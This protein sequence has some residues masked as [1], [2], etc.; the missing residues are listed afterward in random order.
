MCVSVCVWC[1]TEKFVEPIQ[2]RNK[3]VYYHHQ[4]RRVPTIDEC[5]I[6]DNLCMFEANRQL[7]RDRSG[8][9]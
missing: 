6:G 8:L 3:I 4:F 5:D 9:Q 7:D 2:I 1:H